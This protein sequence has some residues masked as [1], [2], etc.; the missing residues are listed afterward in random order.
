MFSDNEN[1]KELMQNNTSDIKTFDV[2]ITDGTNDFSNHAIKRTVTCVSSNTRLY[3]A[4]A[5]LHLD[6]GLL[7]F[8]G[9]YNA[10]IWVNKCEMCDNMVFVY[11]NVCVNT[12]TYEYYE[13]LM[14]VLNASNVYATLEIYKEKWNGKTCLKLRPYYV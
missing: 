1:L 3:S 13:K 14:S 10:S 2:V 7:D 11:F 9:K 6:Y 8:G 5:T 4:I 12:V